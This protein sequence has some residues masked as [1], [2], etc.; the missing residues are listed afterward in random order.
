MKKNKTLI[1][2]LIAIISNSVWSGTMGDYNSPDAM[3]ANKGANV[4]Q[5]F[6]TLSIGPAWSNNGNTQTLHLQPDIEKTYSANFHSNILPYGE[7]FLGVQYRLNHTLFDQ[8][9]IE[10]AGGGRAELKGSIWEDANPNFNNYNYT[11]NI[12]E[13]R[14]MAKTKL[15]M[16]INYYGT[17]PFITAGVGIGFNQSSDFTITPK[18]QEEVAAPAFNT[19]TKNVLTYALGFGLQERLS[20]NLQASIGYEFA[21]WGTSQLAKA[22]GQTVGN[23]LLINNVY[24]NSILLSL[25]YIT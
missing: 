4:L 9:G 6:I 21:D 14:V 12:S 10:I 24:I 8:L 5:K 20:D 18:I 11:Y 15:L 23:G 2:Y 7:I 13:L 3:C 17:M 1:A 25:T 22:D 19:S 16:D